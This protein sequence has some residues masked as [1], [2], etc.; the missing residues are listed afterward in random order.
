MH[1]TVTAVSAPKGQPRRRRGA[2]DDGRG[3]CAGPEREGWAAPRPQATAAAAPAAAV[4]SAPN[5]AV[6]GAAP[7]SAG[8]TVRSWTGRA[9]RAA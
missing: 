5:G 8:A 2:R 4:A 9:E 6:S 7:G 3:S 1:R